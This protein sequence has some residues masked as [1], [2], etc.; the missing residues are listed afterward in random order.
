MSAYEP[1]NQIFSLVEAG[2]GFLSVNVDRLDFRY[3]RSS[4]MTAAI[5]ISFTN[6][7]F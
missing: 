4:F 3:L 7:F 6:D 2:T 5:G 1:V